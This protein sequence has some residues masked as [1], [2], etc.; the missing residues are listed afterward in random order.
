MIDI[1][2][3]SAI[4]NSM[5]DPVVFVDTEHVIRYVNKAG[6]ANYAKWG[7]ILGRSIFDCHN[8]HSCEIIREIYAAF[9]QGEDER[10]ISDSAKHRVY[11]RAVRDENGQLI[12][13]FE[14]YEPPVK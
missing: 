7:D 5:K 13:Y 1:E 14:R 2:I 3:M 8:E 9:E 11:M 10:I 6:V 12:G 4:L